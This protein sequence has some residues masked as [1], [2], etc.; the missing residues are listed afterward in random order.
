VFDWDHLRHFL[1]L[2]RTG[3]LGA[4]ARALGVNQSTVQ[5]RLLALEKT[6]GRTLIERQTSGYVLTGHGRALV[7]HAEQ[8]EAAVTAFE[9]QVGT[10]DDAPTGHLKVASLVTI[11]QRILKSGFIDQ[12]EKRHPGMTV[13]ITLGQRVADLAKGE[14]DIAIRGGAPGGAALISKKIAEL[15]W[16]IYASRD[17]IGRHGQPAQP[18]DLQ[19]FGMIELTDELETIPAA[20]WIRAHA[21]DVRVA[22]RCGNV[23]SAHLAV[24][25]GA[26]IAPLPAVYAAED[27]DLVRLF[28]PVPELNYPI[29]LVVHKDLRR[30]RRIST[31]FEFCLRELKPVLLTGAM[32][33]AAADTAS[34][35]PGGSA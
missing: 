3:S 11:G 6:L 5:R 1:A 31:F 20:R 10:L 13:E 19:H 28:G 25:S 30:Q 21:P 4:S 24:K 12:F 16:G 8:V 22:A 29:F 7:P 17:F 27:K 18:A 32:R 26:G 34:P 14:A 33:R 15:P 2:A 9:R 35:R 23:P